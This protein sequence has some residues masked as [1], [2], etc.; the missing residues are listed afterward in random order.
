MKTYYIAQRTLPVLCVD[1]NGKEIQKR[2]DK[3]I[4]MAD[5]LCYT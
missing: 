1:L 3:G 4:H 5:S 2:W